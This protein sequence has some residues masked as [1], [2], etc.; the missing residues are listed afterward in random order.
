LLQRRADRGWCALCPS[1]ENDAVDRVAVHRV[2]DGT[3]DLRLGEVGVGEVELEPVHDGLIVIAVCFDQEVWVG[4]ERLDLPERHRRIRRVVDLSGLER[5]RAG[6]GVGDEADD[7]AVEIGFARIPV[8]GIAL[9]HDVA[10]LFPFLENEGTSSNRRAS[11]GIGQGIGPL[12][13]VSRH[14]R[15]F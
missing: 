3:P 15:R 12:I 14:D 4:L 7:D 13:D 1:V 5:N 10:A 2:R 6:V 11:V 8:V 9:Q